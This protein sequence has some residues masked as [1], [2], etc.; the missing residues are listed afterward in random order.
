MRELH[1]FAGAGGGCLASR[2]LGHRIVGYVEYD[3]YAQAVLE[4]RIRDG[5]LD[6]APIFGDIRAF[7]ASGAADC[8]RGVADLVSGGFPCQPFSVAGKRRGA[9]DERN[10]WPWFR[11]VLRAVRPRHVFAENVPGL[12][13][14]GYFGTILSDLHALG[15]VGRWGVLSAADVGAPH[16]RERLWIVAHADQPERQAWGAESGGSSSRS[17]GRGRAAHAGPPAHPDSAREHV[18]LSR[19]TRTGGCRVGRRRARAPTRT[20]PRSPPRPMGRRTAGCWLRRFMVGLRP[21][22]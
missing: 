3:A 11:D 1:L 17:A 22:R 18:G 13:G 12:L 6:P 2:L 14:S 16:L 9:D 10:G 21:R 8:Y 7:L 15:Y 5:V 4:A 19:W 20:A